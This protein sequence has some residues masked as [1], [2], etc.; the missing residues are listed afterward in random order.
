[1]GNNRWSNR[2]D[3]RRCSGGDVCDRYVELRRHCLSILLRLLLFCEH[4]RFDVLA[5]ALQI[6]KS[7]SRIP[8]TDR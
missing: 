4:D 3:N 1:M 7:T 8:F 6:N 5:V 2:P